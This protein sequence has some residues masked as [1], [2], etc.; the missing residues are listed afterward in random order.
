MVSVLPS[1]RCTSISLDSVFIAFGKLHRM[2]KNQKK[3]K[4]SPW[5]RKLK[6]VVRWYFTKQFLPRDSQSSS[7][8]FYRKGDGSF[9]TS[10][11]R[12]LS[13]IATTT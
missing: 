13:S 2:L 10:L 7:R 4:Q 11:I 8:I 6:L 5:N 3:A 9:N 12:F 1:S